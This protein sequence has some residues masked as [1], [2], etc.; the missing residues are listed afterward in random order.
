MVRVT[1]GAEQDSGQTFERE[2]LNIPYSLPDGRSLREYLNEQYRGEPITWTDET[3]GKRLQMV[4]TENGAGFPP[5][6]AEEP[7]AAVPG[8][9]TEEAVQSKVTDHMQ[10]TEQEDAAWEQYMPNGWQNLPIEQQIALSE[11]AQKRAEQAAAEQPAQSR[12]VRTQAM[13]AA[14]K[15]NE[16]IHQILSVRLQLP[17]AV[18][19]D[20]LVSNDSIQ[21]QQ[22]NASGTGESPAD[23]APVNQAERDPRELP[24]V[25][26]ALND[27]NFQL[28]GISGRLGVKYFYIRKNFPV[29]LLCHFCAE[30]CQ[31]IQVAAKKKPRYTYILSVYRGFILVDGK[32]LES[33]TPCTSSRCSTS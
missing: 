3:T 5:T 24:E 12:A 19:D 26:A 28:F 22:E 6:N 4:Q 10:S 1:Q 29:P 15:E 17:Q 2:S 18:S 27:K 25:K 23:A 21:N 7:A 33:L 13:D 8:M 30:M 32:E 14:E 20:T 16:D 9:V 31:K 11:R